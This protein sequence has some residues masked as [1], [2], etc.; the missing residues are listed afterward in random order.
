MVP[1]ATEVVAVALVG[2]A[3]VDPHSDGDADRRWPRLVGHTRLQ[4]DGGV[5]RLT[6]RPERGSEPVPAV[7]KT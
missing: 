1:C 6:R 7:A 3:G 2:R 5:E 4:L